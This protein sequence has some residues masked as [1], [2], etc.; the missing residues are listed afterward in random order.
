MAPINFIHFET[1]AKSGHVAEILYSDPMLIFS[2]L[3][4][5]L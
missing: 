5:L 1:T 4:S 2:F 3:G